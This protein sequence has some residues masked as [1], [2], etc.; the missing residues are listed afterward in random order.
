MELRQ[1]EAFLMVA[2]ERSFTRAAA[3]LNLTQP[4]LSARIQQLEQSLNGE[5][6][7][8][9]QRPVALTQLGEIFLSY[10]ERAVRILNAGQEAIEATQAG[11]RGRVTLCCPFS[12]ATYL[13]PD[14]VNRFSQAFP[15]AELVMEAGHSD[16]AF[17]QLT[18][19]VVNLAFTAAFPYIL[20]QTY[21][22]LRLHDEMVV[23]VSAAHPLANQDTI[24]VGQLWHYPILNVHWGEAF[25]DYTQSLQ[26]ISGVAV[27]TMRLPLPVILPMVKQND[28]D[29]LSALSFSH[30]L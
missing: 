18:D 9:N 28:D 24:E 29:Y 20:R 1:L 5:L 11:S 7:K 23:T 2:R 3:E 4:S 8:R 16:F 17:N 6:F 22:L 12:L 21:T 19:N 30:R 27:P 10:A 26:Q 14:V 13:M 15:Q 25:D